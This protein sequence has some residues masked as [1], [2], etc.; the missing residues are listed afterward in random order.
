[1]DGLLQ[2]SFEL[3]VFSIRTNV[4]EENEDDMSKKAEVSS[5]SRVREF[6]TKQ[7]GSQRSWKLRDTPA[8]QI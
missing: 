6:L 5:V 8:S 1:M 7:S 3:D 4:D 2:G